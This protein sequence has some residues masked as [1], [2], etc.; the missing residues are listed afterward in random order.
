M[1]VRWAV[2]NGNWSSTATWDGGTLPTSADDV[3]ADGKTVTIDQ[4]ITVLSLRTTQ[5]TGGT[6]G[7]TF[8]ANNGVSIT[9]TTFLAGVISASLV[10]LAANAAVTV[11]GSF[12]TATQAGAFALSSGTLTINGSISGA[13][14]L[15]SNCNAILA[16]GTGSVVING[17]VGAGSNT[18]GLTMTFSSTGSL[19]I[20]G[21][22]TSS[23]NS[24]INIVNNAASSVSIVGNLISGGTGSVII[25]SVSTTI[26]VT[27]NLT[28]GNGGV[29]NTSNGI[30]NIV[31]TVNA[32]SAAVAP[33]IATTN[34]ANNTVIVNGI[35]IN[36]GTA[37]VNAIYAQRLKLATTF[38]QYWELRDNSSLNGNI[39]RLYQASQI[40]GNPAASNVRL[41]TVYGPSN[42]LTGTL[43]VPPA[44]SVASGVPVDNTTGTAALSPADIAALVGAQVAAAVSSPP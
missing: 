32:T 21:S 40:G 18:G 16:A 1:A 25:C 4:N 13:G 3:H 43:A 33:V 6:V 7:G 38:N 28:G 15:S 11:N 9:A 20:T 19:S 31:G 8:I 14:A 36:S 34:S 37:G 27:G 26:S 22:V 42:E 17:N 10:T 35:I 12:S 30:L 39:I 5:R 29:L 41:G 23:S 44:N 24:S 2:A